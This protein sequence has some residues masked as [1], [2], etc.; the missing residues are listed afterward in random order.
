MVALVLWRVG[1]SKG[2][3]HNITNGY[4]V[5]LQVERLASDQ[6]L[7][8]GLQGAQGWQGDSAVLK[9]LVSLGCQLLWQTMISALPHPAWA[10][11][12]TLLL[13]SLAPSRY[14]L[15]N[16]YLTIPHWTAWYNGC[17]FSM[18]V[19]HDDI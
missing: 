17:T 12:Q 7:Q 15:A 6:G 9:A 5:P 14:H 11:V 3:P 2:L 8:E 19:S 4:D 16:R 10:F 18:W 1:G 13:N